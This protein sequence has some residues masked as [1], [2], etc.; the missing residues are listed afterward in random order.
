MN[1]EKKKAKC[2]IRAIRREEFNKVQTKRKEELFSMMKPGNE[3]RFFNEL[4]KWKIK[5]TDFPSELEFNDKTYRGSQVL[6]GFADSAFQ[7]SRDSR[8]ETWTP[9]EQHLNKKIVVRCEEIHA[10]KEKKKIEPMDME[11][12]ERM[13]KKIPK[14]K[15]PDIFFQ[16]CG[17]LHQCK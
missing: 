13:L 17:T 10:K 14:G 5:G 11:T 12:F 7:Q 8:K 2:S 6:E 16:H 1:E 3:K 15:A 4:K 9:S